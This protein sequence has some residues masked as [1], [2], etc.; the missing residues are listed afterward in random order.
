MK[1]VYLDQ[2]IA[3]L[4]AMADAGSQ[5]AR[6][7]KLLLLGFTE[8]KIICPMPFETV[9]ESSSCNHKKR[10]AIEQFFKEVSGGVCFKHFTSLV[11][12]SSIELVREN[13]FLTPY[14][15]LTQNWSDNDQSASLIADEHAKMKARM[16]KRQNQFI[17]DPNPREI[18]FSSIFPEVEEERCGMFYRDL[19]K[20]EIEPES[21]IGEFEVPWLIETLRSSEITTHEISMLKE[22]VRHH[23][24]SSIPENYADMLLGSLWDRELTIR[25]QTKYKPNDEIDRRRAAVAL[26]HSDVFVTD[27]GMAELCNRPEV[28]KFSTCTV[29]SIQQSS[30]LEAWC[31]NNAG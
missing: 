28:S 25:P 6:I 15:I 23:H 27:G 16:T 17:E 26:V 22:K 19:E 18:S 2:N 7:R 9:T 10:I 5:W 1:V 8:E 21:P 4:L 14:T 13:Y 29:F 31:N 24:W 3:S 11:A 12:E 20:L 30:E